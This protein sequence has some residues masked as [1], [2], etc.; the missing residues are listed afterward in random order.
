MPPQSGGVRT[1]I[2]LSEYEMPASGEDIALIVTL[3]V[4]Q[5]YRRARPE[6]LQAAISRATPDASCAFF[7]LAF[8]RRTIG[9]EIG[10]NPK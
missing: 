7:N 4:F 3:C 10:C 6:S 2:Q 1:R 9:S 8:T 5:P